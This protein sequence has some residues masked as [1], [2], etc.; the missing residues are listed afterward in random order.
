MPSFL[1]TETKYGKKKMA[2]DYLVRTDAIPPTYKQIKRK[3]K[4][5]NSQLTTLLESE[6][7]YRALNTPKTDMQALFCVCVYVYKFIMSGSLTP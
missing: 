2:Y 5:D 7:F 6:N 1:L 4:Q 3:K